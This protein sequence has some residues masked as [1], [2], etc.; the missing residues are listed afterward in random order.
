MCSKI[1]NLSLIVDQLESHDRSNLF[2]IHIE[3]G[4]LQ[5]KLEDC[6]REQANIIKPDIGKSHWSVV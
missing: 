5:K 3:F 1:H 2:V 6:Q 4:K